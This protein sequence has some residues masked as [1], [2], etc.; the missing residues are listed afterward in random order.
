MTYIKK[1]TSG[2]RIFFSWTY[3]LIVVL[4]IFFSLQQRIPS[5]HFGNGVYQVRTVL[6]SSMEPTL[7]VGSLVV[8]KRVPTDQLHVEDIIVFKANNDFLAH[9]IVQISADKILTKGDANYYNDVGEKDEIKGKMIFSI[10]KIGHFFLMIQYKKGKIA[11]LLTLVNILLIDYLIKL[12]RIEWMTM[13]KGLVTN[14][15][16]TKNT[17]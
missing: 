1:I 13:K 16:E 17:L 10:P 11:L 2:L 7:P 5:T 4:F 3:V 6:S 8:T 9:R 15:N 14:G 12:L